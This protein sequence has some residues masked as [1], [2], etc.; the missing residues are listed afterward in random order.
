MDHVIDE[1]PARSVRDRLLDALEALVAD[2]GLKGLSHRSIAR[3]ADVQ[4]S[5]LHYHF[6]TIDQAVAEA[7]ARRAARFGGEQLRALRELRGRRSFGVED[8]VAALWRPFAAL[9]AHTDLAWRNYLCLVARTGDAVRMAHGAHFRDVEREALHALRNAIP[10]VPDDALETGLRLTRSL[11]H[12]EVLLRCTEADAEEAPA[13]RDR[14]LTAF[15]AAGIRAL[16]PLPMTRVHGT[17]AT[18]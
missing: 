3:R 18:A 16:A 7:V 6:G 14:R 11:F 1:A 13:D 10:D 2:R 15:A 12:C 9:G 4:P 17:Q 8:V 5:L